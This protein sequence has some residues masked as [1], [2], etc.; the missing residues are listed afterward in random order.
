MAPLTMLFAFMTLITTVFAQ[1]VPAFKAS[2]S[3]VKVDAQVVTAEGQPLPGLRASNFLVRDNGSEQQILGVQTSELPLDV[4]LLIDVSG[5]MQRVSNQ[6]VE[7]C[8]KALRQLRAGD[9]VALMPF[10]TSAHVLS[11]LSENLDLAREDVDEITRHSHRGGTRIH[12]AVYDAASYFIQEHRGNR[13]RAVIIVTDDM[14]LQ[15]KS[16]LSVIKQLWE[17]DAVLSGVIIP[18]RRPL[19]R[20]IAAGITP[21]LIPLMRGVETLVRESGGYS[22]EST[23]LSVALPEMISR[24]RASYSIYYRTPAGKSG[25]YRQIDCQLT[26]EASSAHPGAHIYTRRGYWLQ[27][28]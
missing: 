12:Q 25:D 11:G 4:I 14:S 3:Q 1:E 23:D 8:R 6:L 5:S 20:V 24:I 16:E 17:A 19:G 10:T 28:P 21:Y 15:N 2:V 22:L 13:R 27:V 18:N 26:S 9:R 7:A